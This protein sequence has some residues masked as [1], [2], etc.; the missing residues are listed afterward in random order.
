MFMFSLLM[1]SNLLILLIVV[2]KILFLASWVFL[3]GFVGLILI[4]MLNVVVVVVTSGATI[5]DQHVLTILRILRP[6]NGS[7]SVSAGFLSPATTSNFK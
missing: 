1:W 7:V 4:T 2:S 3:F 6:G 5:S